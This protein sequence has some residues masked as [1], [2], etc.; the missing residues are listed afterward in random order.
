[1]KVDWSGL[2]IRNTNDGCVLT[3]KVVPRS[4]VNKIVDVENGELKVKIQA[5]P[6]EGAAN[7]AVLRFLADQLKKPKRLLSLVKGQKSRHKTIRIAGAKADDVLETL[8]KYY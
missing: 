5:P 6:V 1:M 3:L 7:E 4:S 2:A 8:K